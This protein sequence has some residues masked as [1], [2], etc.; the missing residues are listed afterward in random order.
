MTETSFDTQ[1]EGAGRYLAAIREHWL[2]IVLLV[3]VA[4]ASSAAYALTATKKYKAEAD[5]LVNPIAQGDTTYT[6]LGLL[7]ESN[8]LGSGVLT[9]TPPSPRMSRTTTT[10]A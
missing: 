4:V 3:V 6:G 9:A 8:A 5:V 10:S 1:R 2:L 7:T